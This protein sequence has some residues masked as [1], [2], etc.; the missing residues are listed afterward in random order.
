MPLYDA[1]CHLQDERLAPHLAAALARAAAAG[2]ARLMCCGSSESDWEDVVALAGRHPAVRMS[3][4][5]HPWYVTDRTPAWLDRLRELL[6]R[7]SAAVG[8]IGLDHVLDKATH[9]AQEEVFLAQLAVARELNRP[10]S[11]HCRQAW[12]RMQELL[13][14]HGVPPAGMLIHSYSGSPETI[15]WLQERGVYVS[16]SCSLTRSGN[17]RG[18]RS[19]AAARAD[20]LLVETDSPD[21]PPVPEPGVTP[22]LH[23]GRPLNE[24]AN[25]GRVARALASVRETTEDEIARLT[26]DN[27]VRLFGD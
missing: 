12:G 23:D 26:W 6:A 5:L 15:A 7:S 22:L 27:A 3:L 17:T 19:A 20:R 2:V 21:I 11:V 24:P 13:A 14:A 16:F 18:H 9:A 4:G 25:L 8:E 1:H 10:V